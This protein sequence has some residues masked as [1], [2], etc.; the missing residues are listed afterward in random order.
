MESVKIPFEAFE[1]WL[2]LRNY[3]KATKKSYVSRLRQFLLWRQRLANT[4]YASPKTKPKTN[5]SI[6][7]LLLNNPRRKK[8]PAAGLNLEVVEAG[9]PHDRV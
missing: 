8:L 2:T 3:A 9:G 5:L 4:V 6:S 7:P 1:D